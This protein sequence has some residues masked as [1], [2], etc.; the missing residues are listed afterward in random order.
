MEVASDNIQKYKAQSYT[1]FS[2]ITEDQKTFSA[3]THLVKTNALTIR[4]SVTTLARKIGIE[5]YRELG[6]ISVATDK[7]LSSLKYSAI[8]KFNIED[9]SIKEDL[10]A[11]CREYLM[12]VLQQQYFNIHISVETSGQHI[13]KFQP[14]NISLVLDN[15]CLIHKKAMPETLIYRWKIFRGKPILNYGMMVM[16][17]EQ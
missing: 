14:Q 11:F 2:A 9:A 13:I 7:I 8:A 12:N 3:K 1:I 16:A 10:F 4:N 5:N 17:L 15:F 6:A